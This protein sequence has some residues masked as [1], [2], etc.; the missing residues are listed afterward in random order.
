MRLFLSIALLVM[1]AVVGSQAKCYCTGKF[2][3]GHSKSPSYMYSAAHKAMNAAG[4]PDSLLTQ[5]YGD[6]AA[7]VGTHCPEPGHTYSLATDIQS[8]SNPCGRTH[9]LRLHGFAAWYRTAPEFPGNNHIHAV[10][11]GPGMKSSLVHQVSSFLE[12]RDGLAGNK[13]D[14]HCPITQA[15]KDAVRKVQ[16]HY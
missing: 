2:A 9:A 15:E 10:Y 14:H 3:C 7:S 8:G 1:V 6:A 12:G 13:I 5:T 4:V 16:G 11:P